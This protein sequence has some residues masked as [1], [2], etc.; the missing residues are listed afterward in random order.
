M[1]SQVRPR[2]VKQAS[3]IYELIIVQNYLP[4]ILSK[5]WTAQG[6]SSQ[7]TPIDDETMP[8]MERKQGLLLVKYEDQKS[9]QAK[10]RP[11]G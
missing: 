10:Y 2:C 11:V 5:C 4:G 3:V 1:L 7:L 9:C 6:S 8:K